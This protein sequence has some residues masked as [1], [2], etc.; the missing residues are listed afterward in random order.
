M[1]IKQ[2]LDFWKDK[3]KEGKAAAAIGKFMVP[4]VKVPTNIVGETITSTP[5]GLALAGLKFMHTAFT[6]GVKKTLRR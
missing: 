6:K 3:E 1:L 2:E 5:A 4:F